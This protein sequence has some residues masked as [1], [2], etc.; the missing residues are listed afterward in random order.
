MSVSFGFQPLIGCSA[1]DSNVFSAMS[2]YLVTSLTKYEINEIFLIEKEHL[3]LYLLRNRRNYEIR[4]QGGPSFGSAS[5]G[6][7]KLTGNASST[8]E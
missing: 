4:S 5:F 2:K 8:F 1:K 3:S 7:L 6:L